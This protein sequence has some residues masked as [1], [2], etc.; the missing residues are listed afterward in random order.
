MFFSKASFPCCVVRLY[1]AST[2]YLHTLSI[3]EREVVLILSTRVLGTVSVL[4]EVRICTP[5]TIRQRFSEKTKQKT[6]DAFA[7]NAFIV[8]QQQCFTRLT[9]LQCASSD[10][11]NFLDFLTDWKTS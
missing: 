6:L 3:V 9:T 10:L 7:Q 1:R 2:V 5:R 4:G 11:V 8:H